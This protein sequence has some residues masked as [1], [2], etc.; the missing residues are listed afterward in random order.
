[1]IKT[2]T[3]FRLPILGAFIL[4]IPILGIPI[5]LFIIFY[6]MMK[7]SDDITL[8]FKGKV[9]RQYEISDDV[10]NEYA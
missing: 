6:W 7:N 8:W 5:Y 3:L 9:Y 10:R 2:L 1:M 4:L